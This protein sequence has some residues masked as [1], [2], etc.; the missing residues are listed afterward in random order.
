MSALPP[1][2]SVQIEQHF[3]VR[4]PQFDLPPEAWPGYMAPI[5]RAWHEVPGELQVAPACFGMVP[6]WANMKLVRQTYNAHTETVAQK[7]S[8]RNAWKRKQFCIIP[9]DNF[10]ETCYETGKPVRQRI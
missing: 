5:I 6:H 1:S 8:F 9:A 10:F 7:P 3:A 2:R 4:S